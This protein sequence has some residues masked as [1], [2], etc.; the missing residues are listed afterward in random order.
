MGSCTRSETYWPHLF[1]TPLKQSLRNRPEEWYKDCNSRI[2]R[3]TVELT[4]QFKPRRFLN[5]FPAKG[6]IDDSYNG[7][8]YSLFLRRS[9]CMR[10]LVRGANIHFTDHRHRVRSFRR[11]CHRGGGDVRK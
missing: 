4:S 7:T 5:Q 8:T 1:T 3:L 9:S 2:L 6:Q 10:S 11:R